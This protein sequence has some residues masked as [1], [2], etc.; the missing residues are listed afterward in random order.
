MFD[1]NTPYLNI[2]VDTPKQ[3][4]TTSF[5]EKKTFYDQRFCI[6]RVIDSISKISLSKDK[7]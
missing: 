6:Y 5:V 1:I 3:G 2:D 7:I 4:F